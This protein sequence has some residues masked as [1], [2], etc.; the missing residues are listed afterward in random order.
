MLYNPEPLL[1]HGMSRRAA[2]AI[3]GYTFELKMYRKSWEKGS[4]YYFLDNALNKTTGAVMD[5]EMLR[6][7][8]SYEDEWWP[9]VTAITG[10]GRAFRRKLSTAYTESNGKRSFDVLTPEKKPIYDEAGEP[11]RIVVDMATGLAE[12][13]YGR[14]LRPLDKNMEGL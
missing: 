12:T 10:D 9:L 13:K 4:A 7:L 11:I 8:E 3:R 6:P 14:A 1:S 2:L 5:F